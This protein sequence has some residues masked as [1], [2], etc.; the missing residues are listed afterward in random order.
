MPG[1]NGHSRVVQIEAPGSGL[2]E[3]HTGTVQAGQDGQI[4]TGTQGAYDA[5]AS[6]MPVGAPIENQDPLKRRI[7]NPPRKTIINAIGRMIKRRL[8]P[9]MTAEDHAKLKEIERRKLLTKVLSQEAA[10]AKGRMQH[11]LTGLGLCWERPAGERSFLSSRYIQVEFSECLMEPNALWFRVSNRLPH[12]VSYT[13]LMEPEVTQ[14][15]SMAV[16]HHVVALWSEEAGLWYMVERASGRFGVPNHVNLIDSWEGKPA[17]KDS[18]TI[19][20]GMG[21]NSKPIYASLEDMVH[22]LVA[23]TTGGGKSNMLN[24]IL[25]TLIRANRPEALKLVMVDLKGGLEFGFYDSIPHLVRPVVKNRDDVPDLLRYVLAE[26][27][28]R[29]SILAESGVQNIGQYNAHRKKKMP[30]M[31]M[32]IDEW[33]DV[34]GSAKGKEC[35]DILI[36]LVQRMRAVGI[37]MILATQIPNKRVLSLNVRANLPTRLA[38][39]CTDLHAS[40][41][42]LANSRAHLIYP[43]GRCV[44]QSPFCPEQQ[45]QTPYIP[46]DLIKSSAAGAVSGN[47]ETI[48]RKHDVTPEEMLDWALRENL[49][50]LSRD[51]LHTHF[52]QRGITQAE[53]NTWLEEIEGTEIVVSTT[54]YTV[55]PARGSRGRRLVAASEEATP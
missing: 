7:A 8:K 2:N 32:I 42:I 55:Q 14:N 33:G 3:S 26:G 16:N 28:H 40:M 23:G 22:L 45:M 51:T 53:I 11:R 12:G 39:N 34:I 17:S 54:V 49:G 50:Y 1:T 52:G 24:V 25:C 47:F 9:E 30:R 18:Y 27:E 4:E 10:V 13:K 21:Q 6:G 19:P 31:V 5:A 48:A 36:N 29:M 44:I 41:S 46:L 20:L 37:H 38:F 15:L 35:E 43:A